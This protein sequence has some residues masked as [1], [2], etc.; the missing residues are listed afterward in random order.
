MQLMVDV[1]GLKPFSQ[2]TLQVSPL[3]TLSIPYLL[4]SHLMVPLSTATYR[5][6]L[7]L[8]LVASHG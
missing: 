6:E 1:D 5:K 8:T 2:V 4:P 3:G 7:P